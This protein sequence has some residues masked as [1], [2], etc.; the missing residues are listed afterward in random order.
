MLIIVGI[1][2]IVG[3]METIT[4]H[5]TRKTLVFGVSIPEPYVKHPQLKLWKKHYSQI[6]AGI[7][8]LFFEPGKCVVVTFLSRI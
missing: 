4:P 7:T 5:L 3:I 8:G 1:F 6:I 2:I